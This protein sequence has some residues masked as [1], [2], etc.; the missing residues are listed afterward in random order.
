MEKL[1]A[2]ETFLKIASGR[3]HTLHSTLVISYINHQKSLA[4]FSHLTPF[5][6]YFFTKRPSQKRGPWHNAPLNTLLCQTI[7]Q[8]FGSPC[9]QAETGLR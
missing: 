7:Q 1:Y 5:A 2:S 8:C 3:I 9:L 4:C 6:L